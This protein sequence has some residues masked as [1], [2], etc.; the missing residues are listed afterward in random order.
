MLYDFRIHLLRLFTLFSHLL[1]TT[2]LFYTKVDSIKVTLNPFVNND[3]DYHRADVSYTGLIAVAV[4][5]LLVEL[6]YA[7][8]ES[9]ITWATMVH[10]FLDVIACL[11]TSWIIL[12]GLP[13]DLY[14][15]VWVFCVYVHMHAFFRCRCAHHGLFFLP[16]PLFFFAFPSPFCNRMLPC[17]Y[18]IAHS[19]MV[20]AKGLRVM[21]RGPRESRSWWP[22]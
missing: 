14:V 3:A 4:I 21:V 6:G 19:I 5:L 8:G 17:F 13:W 9:R 12:D 22:F 2:V 20:A 18:D 15:P 7:A 16:I 1:F 10:V 11:F